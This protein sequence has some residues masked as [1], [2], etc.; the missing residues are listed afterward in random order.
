[1]RT[2]SASF[3]KYGLRWQ[4][5]PKQNP[6]ASFTSGVAPVGLKCANAR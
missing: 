3:P 4:T 6:G 5:L 2:I 1:M